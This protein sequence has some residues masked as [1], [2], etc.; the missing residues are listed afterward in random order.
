MMTHEADI[1]F[2]VWDGKSAGTLLNAMRLISLKKK[3]VVYI[4]PEQRFREFRHHDEWRTFFADCDVD[5]RRKVEQRSEIP[6]YTARSRPS[7]QSLVVGA[8]QACQQR[9]LCPKT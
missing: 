1:G 3:V 8:T 6:P 4:A 2:M 5:L 9:P 7:K